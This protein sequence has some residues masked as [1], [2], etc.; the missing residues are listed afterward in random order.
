MMRR[1]GL[2]T[3]DVLPGLLGYE[4]DSLQGHAPMGT[5]RIAN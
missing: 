5:A 4:V 1:T 3:G 2:R